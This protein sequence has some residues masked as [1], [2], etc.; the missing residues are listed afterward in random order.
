MLTRVAAFYSR[1]R[2]LAPL[3]FGAQLYGLTDILA[4]RIENCYTNGEKPFNPCRTLGV[5][6]AAPVCNGSLI[7]AYRLADF[8]FDRSDRG[9][10]QP[11]V[12]VA[13]ISF[14]TVCKKV[15]FMQ[16]FWTPTSICLYV[17]CSTAL[18]LHFEVGWE[19]VAGKF[20]DWTATRRVRDAELEKKSKVYSRD[21]A[22][23]GEAED[24]APS[25]SSINKIMPKIAPCLLKTY[26]TSGFADAT[27]DEVDETDVQE[28]NDREEPHPA[29]T[30]GGHGP[31]SS[32]NTTKARVTTT[33]M[34][35]RDLER[36]ASD[37]AMVCLGAG[38]S[39]STTVS[40]ITASGS[41]RVS[42]RDILSLSSSSTNSASRV[43]VEGDDSCWRRCAV[44]SAL[45]SNPWRIGF[46]R[47]RENFWEI[48]LMSWFVW[49]LSDLFNFR[50]VQM[51]MTP[52]F[53]ATWDAGV[54]L[55]WNTYQSIITFRS[56]ISF[57]RILL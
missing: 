50:V 14:T 38:A 26:R 8:L 21:D 7:Y 37:M 25:S 23:E 40:S 17:V 42:V 46:L 53:R 11:K 5:M 12:G 24:R 15:A 55:V 3:L 30:L 13:R 16:L 6:A 41:P 44:A 22:L 9:K 10:P 33:R 54:G 35:A 48:Y 39:P 32:G 1:N 43:A 34:P 47:L 27:V 45:F 29:P 31:S 28:E 18:H 56:D 36:L 2:N 49:P 4:N 52:H 19:A 20:A 57:A 51:H